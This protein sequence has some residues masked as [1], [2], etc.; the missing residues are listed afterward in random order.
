AA[1]FFALVNGP[2]LSEIDPLSYTTLFR[3]GVEAGDAVE[4]CCLCCRRP[5]SSSSPS[6]KEMFARASL[7]LAGLALASSP[8]QPSGFSSSMRSEE[9]T[10]ELQS[11]ENLVC[12]LL[13]E[14]QT[15]Y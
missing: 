4:R 2:A 9:H 12:R 6:P 7:D 3:S 14:K 13:L 11:R 1:L 8:V 10:T 5:L 15:T